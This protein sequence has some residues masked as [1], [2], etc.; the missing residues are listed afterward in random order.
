MLST[1]WNRFL[2]IFRPDRATL[3]PYVDFDNQSGTLSIRLEGT[4]GGKRFIFRRNAITKGKGTVR[5]RR[6]QFD[7]AE[8]A[9]LLDGLSHC[10]WV[11]DSSLVCPKTNVPSC[12]SK[13]RSSLRLKQS[14]SAERVGIH[15]VPLEHRTY[16]ELDDPETLIV[17]QNLVSQEGHTIQPP[18]TVPEEWPDWLRVSDQFFKTPQKTIRQRE[19]GRRV[20]PGVRR[21]TNDEVP[22][23]LAE[24]LQTIRKDSRILSEPGVS[25]LRVVTATPSI[26]TQIDLDESTS[27]VVVQ[28]KYVSGPSSIDHITVKKYDRNRVYLRRDKTYHKVDW[29]QIDRITRALHDVGLKEQLDGSYRAPALHYDEIINIFSRLGILSETEIFKRFRERLFGFTNIETLELPSNVRAGVAVRKYQ[30]HGYEWLAFLK[31][32][33]LPGILADEMGLGKTLQALLTMA[34]YRDQYDLCPSLV[35]CPAAIVEKW[36][37]EA[38]RFLSDFS[39]LCYM[40]PSRKNELQQRIGELDMVVTSYDTLAHD[41]DT[42]KQHPW[43]FLIVDEA[44]RIKNPDTQ[45]AQAVRKIPAEARI[46]ITGT[47]VENRLR[48][49]WALFDFLATGYLGSE[50]EFD[51]KIAYPIEKNGDR[52]A[53]ELLLRKTRPF[54]LRRLKKAVA[55]EL[56]DKIEERLKCE[57]TDLQRTLYKAV[58]TRDLEEAIKAT[59]GKKLSL[60]NPHIFAVLTKLKQICCHPGLVTGEFHEF[61]EGVSGKFDVFIEIFD[62]ILESE[63]EEEA[64]NKLLV[65]S[66]Y[67][68]MVSFLQD[69]IVSRG[70]KCDRIDGSVPP[71]QRP[72]LCREFNADPSR[73]GMV[74]TLSSGGVGL[75][76]QSANHV[77]LYDQWWNPAVHAQAI[78]RV[79]RIGQERKVL[80]FTII[81][82]GTLEEKIEAKLAKK[83]D[84][85]ELVIKEDELLRKEITREELIDLVKL[86]S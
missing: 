68:H 27:Q 8:N 66:Q 59:G 16:L 41:A 44:Q 62:E 47:P 82:R 67:L 21:L 83:K 53:Q 2:T 9:A 14:P 43:R 71:M 81:T 31:K 38:E 40:G 75:D 48:D 7:S 29:A 45:R 39:V 13:L 76:L 20:A 6:F 63:S 74:L 65:F 15:P 19:R 86:D 37:D 56:P 72:A 11:D 46:V 10:Q 34:Y 50:G 84:I 4:I 79:H 52:Q 26:A 17:R 77:V 55:S 33:G 58:I 60:G 61:K 12:L 28:P 18:E 49:L 5:H 85:F 80:V 24:D 42:L 22:E 30:H 73:F 51:R 1:L 57:L 70:R 64:P 3:E 32:Y 25:E 36:A 69:F 78:D 54:V 35:V 23:F